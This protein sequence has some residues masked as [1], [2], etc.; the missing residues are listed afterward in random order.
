M[1]AYKIAGNGDRACLLQVPF[2]G[3][4]SFWPLTIGGFDRLL[5]RMCRWFAVV[6]LRRTGK[7]L[8]LLDKRGSGDPL[9]VGL[10]LLASCSCLL[11]EITI[12][13]S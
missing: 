8:F 5:Q 4:L 13:P 12:K 9:V 11:S 6:F 7:Q 2:L 1:H 3:Y 10:M